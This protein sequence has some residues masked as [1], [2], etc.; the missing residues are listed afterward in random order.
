MFRVWVLAVLV[1]GL[2]GFLSSLSY[3]RASDLGQAQAIE[4]AGRVAAPAPVRV[5][6]QRCVT[7]KNW[8]RRDLNRAGYSGGLSYALTDPPAAEVDIVSQALLATCAESFVLAAGTVDEMLS[9]AEMLSPHLS[10]DFRDGEM[11]LA[12]SGGG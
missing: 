11:A 12:M 2:W 9:R 5:A 7:D 6:L 4:E 1:F 10:S 3:I 8:H